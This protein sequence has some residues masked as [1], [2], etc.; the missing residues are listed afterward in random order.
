MRNGWMFVLRSSLFSRWREIGGQTVLGVAGCGFITLQS[1]RTQCSAVKMNKTRLL[2]VLLTYSCFVTVTVVGS[3]SCDGENLDYPGCGIIPS[4]STISHGEPA[5]Y[6]W[7]A[8]LYIISNG[9]SSFCGATLISDIQLIT[10]AHCVSGKTKDEV[11]VLIGNPNAQYELNKGNFKYLF[12]IEVCKFYQEDIKSGWK[13]NPD[14]AVI[15]LEE[16]LLLDSK[17][18]PICLPYFSDT[19]HNFEGLTATVAGW[20]KTQTG[21]ESTDQLLKVD[22]PIISNSKC[23]STY[24]WLKRYLRCKQ[25]EGSDC[26]TGVTHPKTKDLGGVQLL[27]LVS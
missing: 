8:F 22:V 13:Q 5:S 17:T 1:R 11:A 24:K 9:T 20:G 10:A 23:K 27:V 21:Q 3:S 2:L 16:P 7:M 25:D 26:V 6:P 12:K 4:T 19:N 18:N 14:I 15:T